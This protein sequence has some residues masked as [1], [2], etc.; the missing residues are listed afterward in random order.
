MIAPPLLQK[1]LAQNHHKFLKTVL[2]ARFGSV[3]AD[4]ARLLG[5]ILD[6]RKLTKL[7]RLAAKCS[8]MDKFRDALLA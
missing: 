5:D 7:T 6:E 1:I 8:T 3:P 2:K 4:V